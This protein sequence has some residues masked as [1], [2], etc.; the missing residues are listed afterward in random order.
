MKAVLLQSILSTQLQLDCSPRPPPQKKHVLLAVLRSKH[1]ACCSLAVTLG[2]TCPSFN[3]QNSPPSL[4]LLSST[5]R[6]LPGWAAAASS[7][8]CRAGATLMSCRACTA[9]VAW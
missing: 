6:R 4:R 1:R 7:Q 8:A 9:K 5:S 3:L 2:E